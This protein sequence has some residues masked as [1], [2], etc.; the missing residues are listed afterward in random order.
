M[1]LIHTT[2]QHTSIMYV[3]CVRVK[4]LS[5]CYT[6]KLAG[7]HVLCAERCALHKYSS[8]GHITQC[9]YMYHLR[10]RVLSCGASVPL[11][12]LLVI[13]SYNNEHVVLFRHHAATCV[14]SENR[15]RVSVTW[16]P[17]QGGASLVLTGRTLSCAGAYLAVGASHC[18]LGILTLS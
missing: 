8:D 6:P 16:C 17:L 9:M 4:Y 15:T 2:F 13:I 18:V 1:I 11:S 3:W 10:Y 14:L 12:V 7:G 5:S